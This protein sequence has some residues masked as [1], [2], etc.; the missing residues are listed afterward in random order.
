MLLPF[1]CL[2]LDVDDLNVKDGVKIF[3]HVLDIRFPEKTT[4]DVIGKTLDGIFEMAPQKDKCPEGT[5]FPSSAGRWDCAAARSRKDKGARGPAWHDLGEPTAPEIGAA[6]VGAG[7]LLSAPG[8]VTRAA[9][10]EGQG[11]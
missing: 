9:G 6:A 8:E 5:C 7:P 1:L 10:R 3:F 4:V 11:E 2:A